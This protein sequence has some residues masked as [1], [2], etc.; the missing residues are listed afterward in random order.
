MIKDF[1][2]DYKIDKLNKEVEK[3]EKDTEPAARYVAEKL[4]GETTIDGINYTFTQEADKAAYER[5]EAIN[6]KARAYRDK[7]GLNVF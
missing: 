4:T 7:Y 6:E 3:A 1:N 2:K 5:Q